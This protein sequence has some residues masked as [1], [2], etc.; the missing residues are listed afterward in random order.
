MTSKN[1]IKSKSKIQSDNSYIGNIGIICDPRLSTL[2]G[3]V[4]Q[5]IMSLSCRILEQQQT[6][7]PL[8][9]TANSKET[10]Y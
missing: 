9:Q 6:A 8:R 3:P 5:K 2:L 4:H 7:K 10:C 1:S